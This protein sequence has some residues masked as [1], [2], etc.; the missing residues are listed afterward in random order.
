MVTRK[1]DTLFTFC[2][3]LLRKKFIFASE[4]ATKTTFNGITYA[5]AEF[6]GVPRVISTFRAVLRA[7]PYDMTHMMKRKIIRQMKLSKTSTTR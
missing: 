7:K 1:H 3:S 6:K 4:S 5:L 2:F